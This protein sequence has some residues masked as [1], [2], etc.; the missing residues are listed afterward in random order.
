M[1]KNYGS[2]D[3]M[4]I[5]VKKNLY[6]VDYLIIGVYCLVYAYAVNLILS[7]Y[8]MAGD[9]PVVLYGKSFGWGRL[10]ICIAI[11]EGSYFVK[12]KLIWR[13]LLNK[14]VIDVLFL[15]FF[16]PAIMSFS[17]FK[18][19]YS[20]EFTI[21]TL[22][23]WH[24]I[25]IF[26]NLFGI[27]I[28]KNYIKIKKDFLDYLI[29]VCVLALIILIINKIGGVKIS[30]DLSNVYETRLNFQDEAGYSLVLLK[31]ALGLI[32]CPMLV[33]YYLFVE[34][35]IMFI[36]ACA[37]QIVTYSMGKDKSYLLLLFIAITIGLAK[38]IIS[39]NYALAFLLGMIILII[40]DIMA[41]FNIMQNFIFNIVI[42]RL[43]VMPIWL[44][45]VYFNYFYTTPKLWWRQDTFLVDKFF[46]PVYSQSLVKIISEDYFDGWILSPNCGMIGEAFTRCGYFGI[47]IYPVIIALLT[48][49]ISLILEGI[50]P[51][52]LFVFTIGYCMIICN[53][54]I[55][56]T[57]VTGIL[58]ISLL[59][60]TMMRKNISNKI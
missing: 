13:N 25:I 20:M 33:T 7:S 31:T 6:N 44:Q 9:Y 40:S 54:I 15:F 8:Y 43:F 60:L 22:L 18:Y 4:E 39:E 27:K 16:F 41:I 47:I 23:Y 34:K 5:N 14:Y 17:L 55:T 45:N 58:L 53:D 24:F 42:R 56:S 26:F 49:I 21:Y 50:E 52:V 10:I 59:V 28:K 12:K 19:T 57:S 1:V 46:S 37:M 29:L 11:I 36:I 32:I 35:Y 30:I 3:G 2:D 38:K 51:P 48:R